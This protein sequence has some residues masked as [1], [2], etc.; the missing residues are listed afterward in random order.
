MLPRPVASCR[1][2]HRSLNPR[3]LIDVGF[4]SLAPRMTLARTLKLYR[5]APAPTTPGLVPLE[6]CDVPGATA[7][8]NNYLSRFRLAQ[9]FSEAEV[10]HW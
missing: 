5:L 10:A 3:K 7:L 2:W 6:E 9:R 1:Y 8:L 4:S